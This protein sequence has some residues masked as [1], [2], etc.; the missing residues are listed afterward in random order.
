MLVWIVHLQTRLD[1][2]L[3]KLDRRSP[4]LRLG[5]V[6]RVLLDIVQQLQLDASM[7]TAAALSFTTILALVPVFAVSFAIFQAFAPAEQIG[8]EV[9]DLLVGSGLV[10]ADAAL[11]ST[12]NDF[13]SRVHG[14]A[15]GFVGFFFLLVTS[16]SLFMSVEQAFNRIW[17]VPRSRAF[18]R[19]LLTFYAVITLT[20]AL[21]ASGIIAGRWATHSV[22]DWPTLLAIGGTVVPWALATVALTLIY[23][24]LP[25]TS[26]RWRAALIGGICAAIAFELGKWAFDGYVTAI[27]A[28]SVKSRIYGSMALLPVFFLLVYVCWIIML[29]GTE[30]AY[31]VQHHRVLTAEV[32]ERRGRAIGV[33]PPPPTGYLVTRVFADIGLRFRAGGGGS[34]VEEIAAALQIG[35]DEA[36]PAVTALKDAELL[37]AVG[38]DGDVVPAK[39]LDQVRLV[40]LYRVCEAGGYAPGELPS[41][42]RTARLEQHLEA[43]EA[44]GEQALLTS[45][46]ALLDRVTQPENH[47]D[48]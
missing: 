42:R 47:T 21:T 29:G 33:L 30:L 43:A 11:L 10:E 6:A 7:R 19:R 46:A 39:P 25:H 16:T 24:L 12:V 32:R 28:G 31:M 9:H 36:L 20:P 5:R 48:A 38:E 34:S 3:D 26:V 18:H 44:A 1:Q 15:I 17:R 27:W 2:L 35:L 40:D 45:I 23:K 14:R 8:K 37:L 22:H 41:G 4:L 13:L